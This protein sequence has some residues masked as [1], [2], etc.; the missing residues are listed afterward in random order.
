[1]P[2]TSS[3]SVCSGRTSSWVTD[4]SS[5]IATFVETS[6]CR[7]GNNPIIVTS[8]GGTGSHWAEHG[9]NSLYKVS[10][11]STKFKVH[12]PDTTSNAARND[13][14]IN[15]IGVPTITPHN[16][17]GIC[18]GDTGDG[19]TPWQEYSS[20]VPYVDV[21]TSSCGFQ[22]APVYVTSVHC[23]GHCKDTNG[24]SEVYSPTA[25]G[26]RIYLNPTTGNALT[27]VKTPSR[28]WHIHW[29]AKSQGT[30]LHLT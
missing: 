26:F 2:G 19:T 23:S 17:D 18:S 5:W 10:G 28:G 12:I 8:L 6:H 1:M 11:S 9:S 14:H 30:L 3:G 29:I 24:A 25:T 13:W 4:S 16:A 21:D 20:S 27:A 15:F 22:T 7:L